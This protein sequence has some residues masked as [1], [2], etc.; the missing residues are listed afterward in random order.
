MSDYKIFVSQ[1]GPEPPD[2]PADAGVQV[3][4]G[5]TP[6]TQTQRVFVSGQYIYVTFVT[7]G[8]E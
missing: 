7:I 2:L 3:E 5:A 8:G 4:S 6:Q 1:Y